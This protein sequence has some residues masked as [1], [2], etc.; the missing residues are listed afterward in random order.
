MQQWCPE[1]KWAAV[2][3]RPGG[4]G[5]KNANWFRGHGTTNA[6]RAW[7]AEKRM[8][9]VHVWLKRESLYVSEIDCYLRSWRALVN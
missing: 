6:W 4:C 3:R 5:K 8:I 2:P 9:R 1:K 7:K